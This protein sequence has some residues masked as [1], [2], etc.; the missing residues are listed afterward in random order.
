MFVLLPIRTGG[1]LQ[2]NITR[3]SV[4]L[5]IYYHQIL[6]IRHSFRNHFLLTVT[7]PPFLSVRSLPQDT[8]CIT[9][10][11]WSAVFSHDNHCH[12]V[13]L[14]AICPDGWPLSRPAFISVSLT[15]AEWENEGRESAVHPQPPPA[16]QS[17]SAPVQTMTL[18]D[19][20]FTNWSAACGSGCGL[21]VKF[22][23]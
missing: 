19:R 3:C 2:T 9:E 23:G 21:K 6:Y 10:C 7:R 15:M 20:T 1:A 11:L 16:P 4:H 18:S 8:L 13:F 14:L 17:L 22:S 12:R 5:L